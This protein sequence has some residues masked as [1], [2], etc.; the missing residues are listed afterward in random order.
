MRESLLVQS[1]GH[2][3]VGNVLWKGLALDES[4][5]DLSSLSD[6]KDALETA[7]LRYNCRG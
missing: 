3:V 6:E 4:K 2:N 7:E 5:G 1:C